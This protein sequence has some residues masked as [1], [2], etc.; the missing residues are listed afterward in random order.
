MQTA[1][2]VPTEPTQRK[3]ELSKQ[4]N[5]T[6]GQTTDM[7]TTPTAGQPIRAPRHKQNQ[8][9][10]ALFSTSTTTRSIWTSPRLKTKLPTT[11]IVHSSVEVKATTSEREANQIARQLKRS[12][13]GDVV[14]VTSRINNRLIYTVRF[15]TY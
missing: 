7:A 12:G 10:A 8:E 1:P 15:G 13:K 3:E 9:I 4:L 14:I 11:N 2:L 5:L 6:T